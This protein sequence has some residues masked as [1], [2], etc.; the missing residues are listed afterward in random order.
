MPNK[1]RKDKKLGSYSHSS[2]KRKKIPTE[3]NEKFMPDEEKAPVGYKPEVR[4]SEGAP[5]LSWIRSNDLNDA[6]VMPAHPLYIH[7]K[8]HP[9]NFLKSL[10]NQ[11]GGG[12]GRNLG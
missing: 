7:E 8:I 4:K 3:Q 2:S 11:G 9:G 6:E 5:M 1:A 10:I 12:T